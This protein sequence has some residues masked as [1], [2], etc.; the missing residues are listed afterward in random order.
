MEINSPGDGLAD[1]EKLPAFTTPPGLTTGTPG[2]SFTPP[3]RVAVPCSLRSRLAAVA[4]TFRV[5]VTA[6][7]GA[8]VPDQ[9]PSP[10]GRMLSGGSPLLKL[11]TTEPAVRGFPQSS[12][13]FTSI[14]VGQTAGTVKF[15]P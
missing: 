1:A 10:R 2:L 5:G 11:V 15:E 6:F 8:H 7:L 14:D 13:T 4:V 3:L 9:R 12:T